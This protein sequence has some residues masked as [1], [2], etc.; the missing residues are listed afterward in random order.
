MNYANGVLT[1]TCGELL[2]SQLANLK[3]FQQEEFFC[4]LIQELMFSRNFPL[5]SESVIEQFKKAVPSRFFKEDVDSCILDDHLLSKY[6]YA[7][8]PRI[9]ILQVIPRDYVFAFKMKY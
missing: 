4:I 3:E 9:N 7:K 1:I 5:S 8:H 2:E 6:K